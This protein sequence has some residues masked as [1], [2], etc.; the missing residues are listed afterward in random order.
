MET[1]AALPI[2]PAASVLLVRDG[3]EGPEVFMVQRHSR[4]SVLGGAW[5]FPGGKVDA[6]DGLAGAA[7][8][9]DALHR[10]LGEPD[11]AP[12]A[13][14]AL[15]MAALR[16]AFE[17]CG[18]LFAEGA[19]AA[20]AAQAARL[21]GEGLL[22]GEALA[23]LGLAPHVGALQPWS[24]WITPERSV[25]FQGRR[26]DTRFFLAALPAGQT[27]VH[28]DHEAVASAWLTP[29]EA[30]RRYWDGEMALAPPQIM[31]LAHIGHLRDVAALMAGARARP[32]YCVRPHVFELDG[33]MRAMAYPGDPAHPE[34]ERAMPGPL[35]LKVAGPGRFEP[36]EG[37]DAFW[38]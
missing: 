33:G 3:A 1:P 37:F 21:C 16:E 13:A 35:R 15:C 31:S 7:A 34:R 4:S 36:F 28:D 30:L 6:G 19:D 38:N 26:F 24:R 18:V 8:Q 32:P 17:E 20:A 11:L 27:A 5:V 25:S 23:R 29:R 22:F 14:L 10:Q 12:D 9:A 2:E